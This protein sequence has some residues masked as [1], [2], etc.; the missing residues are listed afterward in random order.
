MLII[1]SLHLINLHFWTYLELEADNHQVCGHSQVILYLVGSESQEVCCNQDRVMQLM[2]LEKDSKSL[3]LDTI[4][5]VVRFSLGTE[6][7]FLYSI[8]NSPFAC[9]SSSKELVQQN[10]HDLEQCFSYCSEHRDTASSV[11]EYH[12]LWQ[13]STIIADM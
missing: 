11:I 3:L 12:I 4:R 5:I 8:Y 2:Q 7:I 13:L 9:S 6:D 1:R 10:S